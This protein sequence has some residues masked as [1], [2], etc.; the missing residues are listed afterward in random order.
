MRQSHDA[1]VL[2]N[3]LRML[4]LPVGAHSPA[5]APPPARPSDRFY[6]RCVLLD[7]KVKTDVGARLLR[8]KRLH[9]EL[10]D[11]GAESIQIRSLSE[12]RRRRQTR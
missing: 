11:V 7:E 10:S 2:S 6:R 9:V 8:N 3:Q 12:E 1:F 4:I 5:V